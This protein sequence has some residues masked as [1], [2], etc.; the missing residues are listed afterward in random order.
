MSKFKGTKGKWY[1]LGDKYPSIQ[2]RNTDPTIV[3]THPSIAAVNSTFIPEQEYTANAKLIAS[4]PEMLELLIELLEED[5]LCKSDV[6]RIESI[7]KKAIL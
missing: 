2:S 4:A 3:Q 5:N 6:F 7:I 1:V